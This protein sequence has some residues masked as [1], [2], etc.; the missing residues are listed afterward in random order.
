M[1]RQGSR[2]RHSISNDMSSVEFEKQ[3]FNG[4]SVQK[5]RGDKVFWILHAI[6]ASS[7]DE[8]KAFCLQLSKAATSFTQTWSRS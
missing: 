2:R 4:S 6:I 3:N 5:S 7:C 8:T 1:T